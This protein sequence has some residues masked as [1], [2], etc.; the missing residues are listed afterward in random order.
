MSGHSEFGAFSFASSYVWRNKDRRARKMAEFSHVEEGSSIDMLIAA[1][2]KGIRPDLRRK[3]FVHALDEHRH[4]R[5]FADRAAA[6]S[7]G[8]SRA[9]SILQDRVF[10]QEHGIRSSQSLIEHFGLAQFL[11]FV[12]MQEAQAGKQFG[13]IAELVRD[14]PQTADFFDAVKDDERFHTN[15]SRLELERLGQAQGRSVV[16]QAVRAVTWRN[17]R[18]ALLRL[19]RRFSEMASALWLFALFFV[20]LWPF[21]L[22]ARVFEKPQPGFIPSGDASEVA[23]RNRFMQA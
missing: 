22:L 10:I 8:S 14:D 15:Y 18:N 12:W 9:Q 23:I 7:H 2:S 5:G 13:V 3:F 21:A 17:R 4:A 20:V 19:A 11:A 6:L 1:E 16:T